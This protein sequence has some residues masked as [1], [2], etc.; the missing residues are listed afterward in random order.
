MKFL[1]YVMALVGFTFFTGCAAVDCKPG[2]EGV[3]Y[4]LPGTN[5]AVIGVAVDTTGLPQVK[6]KEIIMYPGQKVLYAGPDE[7]S[8]FFKNKK[9]PNRKIENPSSKGV[10]IIQ[11][12]KDI[13]EQNEFAEE[14]RKTGQVKFNYGVRVNGKELDPMII[15]K[16]DN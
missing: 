12:P 9:T 10:V 1:K 16:R 6:Y 2:K 15:I 14:F 8:V 13:L 4:A 3:A 5:T 11:I 7:F